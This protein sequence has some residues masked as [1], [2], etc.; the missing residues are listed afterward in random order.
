MRPSQLR[1]I[2]FVAVAGGAVACGLTSALKTVTDTPA[3]ALDHIDQAINTLGNQSA[4]WQTTLTQLE[5]QLRDDAQATLANEV[6]QV[7]AKGVSTAGTEIRCNVDFVRTRMRQDLQR[8]SARLKKQ[9][10]PP[11]EP[12]LCQVVPTHVDMAHLPN[13]LEY[14]GYDLNAGE[15]NGVVDVVLR[16]DGGETP[17]NAW[18]NRPTHYLMTVDVRAAPLCNKENRRIAIRFGGA[19]ISTVAVTKRVCADAPAAPPRA[20]SR[21]LW[22]GFDDL[23]GGIGGVSEDRTYGGPTSTGYERLQCRVMR[24]QG[25]GSCTAEGTNPRTGA[26]L[27]WVDDNPRNGTCRVHYGIAPLQ[28]AKCKIQVFEIGEQQPPPPAPDCGCK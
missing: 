11:I 25:G 17:L 24:E 28:G 23:A 7:A 19:D 9:P 22:E 21:I 13:Q 1:L 2:A 18:V 8:L 3:I 12:A 15:P 10:V 20:A 16:Y 4:S 14:Y 6:A 5:G 26:R 27:G